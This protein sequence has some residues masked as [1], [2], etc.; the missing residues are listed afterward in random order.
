M[1]DYSVKSNQPPGEIRKDASANRQALIMSARKLFARKGPEVPLTEIA[2]AAN[3]SRA[4]FYRNFPDRSALITAVFHYNLDLLEQYAHKVENQDDAFFKLMEAV[5]WQQV[6]F[7]MLIPYLS[8]DDGQMNQRLC[9]IFAEPV[10]QTKKS[11]QLR[12]DFNTQQDLSML[13][14]MVGGALLSAPDQKD[15]PK[16]QRAMQFLLEGLRK[17]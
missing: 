10:Q 9:E 15:K 3:V 4:T 13:I 14:M 16:A 17:G 7:H 1:R 8:E 12:K 6:E 2:K 11:G 5:M